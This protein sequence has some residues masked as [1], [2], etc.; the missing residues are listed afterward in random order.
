LIAARYVTSKG[1]SV[2]RTEAYVKRKQ[3]TTGSRP[4][5]NKLEGLGEWE[6]KLQQHFS[7]QARIIPGRKGGKVEFEFYSQED[8]ERLLEAWGVL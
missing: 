6:T 5:T 8:L 2:R 1:F 3:R 7:T 4:R